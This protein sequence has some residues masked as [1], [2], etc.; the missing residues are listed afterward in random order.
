MWPGQIRG[1]KE[2]VGQRVCKGRG[3]GERQEKDRRRK[4]KGR[5][6]RER[7]EKGL[8]REIRMKTEERKIRKGDE[9]GAAPSSTPPLSFYF[10]ECES[11]KRSHI[12]TEFTLLF[13]F[14]T[15]AFTSR[16]LGVT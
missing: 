9:A 15:G 3:V 7:R 14:S 11:S 8:K 10:P 4:E 6:A 2:G 5:R 12:Y 1:S 13:Y 16:P